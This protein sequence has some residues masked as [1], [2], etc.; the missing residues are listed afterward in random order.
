M[1]RSA[2]FTVPAL[3][4]GAAAAM[5]A[6]H[7]ADDVAARVKALD[8]LLA[9][10]WQYQLKES[11]EFATILG[12]D[13]YN[14]RWSD[15]SL[16]H[17]ARQKKATEE[18]LARFRAIDTRGFDE[19]ERLNQQL[20]VRQLDDTLKGIALKGY[21]M[22]LDQFNGVHLGL[23]QFVASIPFDSTKHYED[24]LARL[25]KIPHLVDSL[26]A[27]L[28][29]G[30]KDGLMPP[31]FLLEKVVAQC[32]AIAG[33]AGSANVF[34][35]PVTRFPDAIGAKDRERLAAAVVKAVDGKVR[36]AYRALADFVEKD[37]APKGRAEPGLW[38]LP[39]GAARYR[40][41]VEQM[42]TTTMD[43]EA[44]HQLGLSEVKRI[45]GERRSSRKSSAT[46]ISP[47]CGRR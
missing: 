5:P 2:W 7:A 20:M 35:Q 14:D 9:E 34:G 17:V 42:T 44:I 29:Q 10:Q 3:I 1:A 47:R 31:R 19:Q 8:A 30:E 23:A 46:P 28:K 43:P 40:F 38:A 27:V 33:P 11:P 45:E 36:P 18:F 41:A 39:D 15:L 6:A 12:D 22:P 13:R 25:E 37:Y 4:L 24:Y 16:A 21:E 26:V 32:R